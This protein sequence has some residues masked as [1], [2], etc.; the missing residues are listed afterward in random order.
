MNSLDLFLKK[1]IKKENFLLSMLVI[2]SLN[3]YEF[4]NPY[5]FSYLSVFID[6]Y[7]SI[8]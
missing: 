5:I 3:I 8:S 6:F 1:Q 7:T 4:K 2:L